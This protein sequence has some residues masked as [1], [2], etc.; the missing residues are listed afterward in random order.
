[1]WVP[2]VHVV[3][4]THL[5]PERVLAAVRDF[6]PRRAELWPDVHVEH[7]RVHET[8]TH[9]AVVTEGNPWPMGYVW[10]TLRYDWSEPGAVRG[11]VVASNIFR[12]GSTWEVQ[13]RPE[14][15]GSRVDLVAVRHLK[16]KGWLL[17]PFFPLGLARQTVAQHLRHFL[18]SIEST[19]GQPY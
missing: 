10:E 11:T 12:A 4:H 14:G 5:P 19:D 17:A 2:Q 3:D 6:S 16:G 18:T 13:A 7:L 9:H 1:V 8:G 15:V